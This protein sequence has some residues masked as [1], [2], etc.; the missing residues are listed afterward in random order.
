MKCDI[1]NLHN[2]LNINSSNLDNMHTV[3]NTNW[4]PSKKGLYVTTKVFSI[5]DS[6]SDLK[7]KD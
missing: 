3:S 2:F 5:F 6:D 4:D 1:L 7:I